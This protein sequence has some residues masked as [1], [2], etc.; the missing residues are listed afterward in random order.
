[1]CN[2]IHAFVFLLALNGEWKIVTHHA[3]AV[4]S[5][6]VIEQGEQ[7]D[8]G[9]S[10]GGD[11]CS[12][13]CQL[14]DTSAWLCTNAPGSPTSCCVALINPVTNQT[15]C[16]CQGVIVDASLGY[17]VSPTCEKLNIDECMLGTSVCHQNAVCMD[18]D[19][20]S[21]N[22]TYQC[23]CPPGLIGDG[24]EECQVYNFQTRFSLVKSNQQANTFNTDAFRTYLLTSGTIN[25]T[26]IAPRRI[27]IDVDP[28]VLPSQG[29]RRSLLQQQVA[30]AVLITVTIA[31]LTAEQ[32][33]E[34][35]A[36][37]INTANL[38]GDASL[39]VQSMP[40]SVTDEYD[41]LG[42][43]IGTTATGF[44]VTGVTYNETDAT[45]VVGVLYS[46]GAP[47]VVSTLYFPRV[48]QPYNVTMRNTY[49]VSQHPCM[50]S[51]SV[52]CMLDYRDKYQLGSF[53]A[54]VTS[55][56][57]TCNET[58]AATSTLDL[59]FQPA[60]SQNAIDHALDEFPDSWIERI[61]AG[62]IK[63]HIAQ[64]DL[65]N[66]GLA[67][68]EPAPNNQQ[69]YILTFFVGMTHFTLLPANS[70]SVVASQSK[71][72]L[73]VTNTLTFSFATSQDYTILRYITVQIIQNKWLQSI[74]ERKMQFVKVDFVL[75]VGL[76]Q[77]MNTGL[78]PLQSIR[79]AIAKTQPSQLN[80][81]AWTNPCFSSDGI[82]GMYDSAL[83]YYNWYR[84]AQQQS[85]AI[86]AN[87]CSNP[88]TSTLS[89]S[90]LSNSMVSFFFPVGDNVINATNMGQFPSP[91]YLYVYFQLSV[92]NSDGSVVLSNL[93][94]KAPLDTLVIN[95]GCESLSSEV[96]AMCPF[97]VNCVD[98][99]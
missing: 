44:K 39:S 32:Q 56:L 46:H 64:T 99:D 1:M 59:G 73:S 14:E 31:S 35:T 49:Y 70:L 71:V 20:A 87:M 60:G 92:V 41:S 7:C 79:F 77:N 6:G 58:V 42:E 24:V 4:C 69:G 28:Y 74:I 66:N 29:T 51:Q 5:N 54:N 8:D 93:F 22:S 86:R 84:Q 15:V 18:L 67:M 9:N 30:D 94:A 37:G 12:A 82:S 76:R 62:E 90:T 61:G 50:V 10:F 19:A 17:T 91:Y 27:L 72:Q 53:S 68:K 11:G 81:D 43:P 88:P 85:C 33:A 40:S 45:W 21:S 13:T 2:N 78:V 97:P 89:T 65:S 36:T 57:G 83:P 63:L 95:Y 48:R 55:N 34:V 25:A 38:Q 26:A 23:I 98:L 75:P 3:L 96:C 16:N 80:A 47:N 52:C